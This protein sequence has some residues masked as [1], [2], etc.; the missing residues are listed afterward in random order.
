MGAA[1]QRLSGGIREGMTALFLALVFVG[2][3]AI[4]CVLGSLYYRWRHPARRKLDIRQDFR[5]AFEDK[6]TP[7]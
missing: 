5:V 4:G 7:K 6:E 1:G 2:C 3:F